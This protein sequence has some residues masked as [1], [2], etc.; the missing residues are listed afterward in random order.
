M[1]NNQEIDLWLFEECLEK[2][3]HLF[4]H[5]SGPSMR[6]FINSKEKVFIQRVDGKKIKRGDIVVFYPPRN[7]SQL[8]IH[9]VIKVYKRKRGDL[10]LIK[11]D[12]CFLEDGFIPAER[13]VAEVNS[14]IKGKRL[15]RLNTRCLKCGKTTIAQL[16]TRYTIFT[17]EISI[18]RWVDSAYKVFSTGW[19]IRKTMCSYC[20]NYIKKS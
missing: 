17:D 8:R 7:K 4:L 2:N 13:I 10:F 18:I 9:R 16:S 11:G 15:L 6:P 20:A 3:K 14:I 12:A 1:N 19:K 5:P